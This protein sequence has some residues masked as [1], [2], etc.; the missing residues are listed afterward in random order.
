MQANHANGDNA[1]PNNGRADATDVALEQRANVARLPASLRIERGAV[2]HHAERLLR[3]LALLLLTS[4][5]RR[6][7]MPTSSTS[8]PWR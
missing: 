2:E 4:G 3:R 7:A 1:A 6:H 5:P 8:R